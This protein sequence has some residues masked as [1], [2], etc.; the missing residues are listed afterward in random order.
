MQRTPSSRAQRSNAPG[1]SLFGVANV[2]FE[3]ALSVKD[4]S[5][6]QEVA[7]AAGAHVVDAEGIA[8]LPQG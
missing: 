2:Q 5:A 4:L 1:D 8:F 3:R 7:W 6:R